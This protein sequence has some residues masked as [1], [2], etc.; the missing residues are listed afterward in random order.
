MRNML[1]LW[2]I[3]LARKMTK[4]SMVDDHLELAEHWQIV[5]NYQELDWGLSDS[6]AFL[7]SNDTT[8]KDT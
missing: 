5:M 7:K 1:A 3:Q 6:S 8:D 2:L 4:W